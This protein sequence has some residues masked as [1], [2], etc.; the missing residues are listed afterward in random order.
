MTIKHQPVIRMIYPLVLLCLLSQAQAASSQLDFAY[1]APLSETDQK[2]QRIELPL[3]VILALTRPDLSDLAVFNVNGKQLPLSITRSPALMSQHSQLLP[4]HEFN[5]FQQ[6]RSRI[7]TTREKNQQ[8]GSELETTETVPVQQLRKDYLIEL[9]LDENTPD[10]ERIE[11]QWTHQPT[12]QILELKV[13][14]GNEIDNLRVIKQRKSLT[15]LESED[16]SWRSI[17]G[18]PRGYRYM[19]LTPINAVTEFELQQVSGHYQKNRT[20]PNLTHQITPEFRTGK[21]GDSYFFEFPSAVYAE[22]MRIVPIDTNSVISGDLYAT[23][24]NTD[25]GRRVQRNFRQHNISDHEV[26]PSQPIKLSRRNYQ[27]F[28]FTSHAELAAAPRVVLVYPQY[29]LIFLGDS[30]GPY[31]L[32]WGNYEIQAEATDLGSMLE[33]DLPKARQ[34]ATL[35]TL[36]SIVES[37][38]PTRLTPQPA[39]PWKKWMLWALLILAAIITGRMAFKLYR[40]MNNA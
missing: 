23:W 17:S 37:G 25:D 33:A 20:A 40:E 30:N 10:F 24:N 21:T 13:E 18:I 1:Q 6:Q 8:Q 9:A 38:G 5:S 4:F 29:E 12:A 7:V 26:R 27:Q 32:F 35:V 11:L 31:T 2:L 19:R 14:V 22:A 34:R 16:R 3:E 36:G 15:N 28:W 39:L